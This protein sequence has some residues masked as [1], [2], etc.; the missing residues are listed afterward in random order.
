MIA[1]PTQRRLAELRSTDIPRLQL[2]HVDVHRERSLPLGLSPGRRGLLMTP[3]RSTGRNSGPGVIPDV[4]AIAQSLHTAVR[5]I[6]VGD[7]WKVSFNFLRDCF[8]LF[9]SRFR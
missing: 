3:C 6:N 2:Y 1:V 8:W 9:F 4:H 5:Q 7:A